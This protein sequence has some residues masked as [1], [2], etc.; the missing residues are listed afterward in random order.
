MANAFAKFDDRESDTENSFAKF[1]DRV[2]ATKEDDIPLIKAVD[3]ALL[4]IPGASTLGEFA[5]GANRSIM[6]AL[7][8]IGPDNIN[9]ILELGGSDFKV[10]RLSNE[11]AAP[12]GTFQDGLVGDIAGTAG[13]LSAAAVG[14]GALLKTAAGALP[15]V[16][17][18]GESASA[19]LLRQLGISK[20]AADAIG[21]AA[22][23]A[24]A[25]I[26][27]EIGGERGRMIGGLLAPLAVSVPLSSAKSQAQKLLNKSAPSSDELKST[28]SGIYKSLDEAGVTIPTRNYN[29]LADDIAKT[30]RKEGAD[31]D[32][33]PKAVAV[34]NRL[35]SDKGKDKTLSELDTLRKIANNAASSLDPADAR[36]GIIAKQKIDDFLDDIPD[37][38]VSGKGTGAAYRSARDL[39]QRARKSEDMDIL[40][41]NADNQASGLENG[42]RVQFRSLLK[43]INTGK[44]KGYSKEE[45]EAIKKIVQGTRP[46]NVARFLG[47]F[48]VMDGMTSRTLTTMGG[49]GLA[50]AATGSGG[51]ALAV[52]LVGQMSGALAQRMTKDGAKM[53]QSLI[54]AGKDGTRISELYIKNTPK[55]LRSTTELAELLLAN[56]V[57]LETIITKSPLLSDAAVIAAAAQIG[58]KKEERSP[59]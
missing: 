23:G 53:A 49:A 29:S 45:T 42:I 57:P 54:R 30:L 2:L 19:G 25:E 39:W 35:A 37:E 46:A 1:D 21:G 15:R 4:S 59:Q 32:L 6:G 22:S 56:K 58:D 51:V 26:G 3:D 41:L 17:S 52:P 47:K 9:A 50:G 48:G 7:D 44:A 16:A 13:E 18:A 38:V 31:K 14:T 27:E 12:K 5:A 43:K 24:G 36:L 34:I 8:F 20:P 28:A 11:L 33:T 55:N 10:P 40:L